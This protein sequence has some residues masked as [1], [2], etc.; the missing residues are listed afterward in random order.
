MASMLSPAMS[1]QDLLGAMITHYE[2]GSKI[3]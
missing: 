1:D 3:V 2:P